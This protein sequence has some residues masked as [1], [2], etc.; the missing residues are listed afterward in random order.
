MLRIQTSDFGTDQMIGNHLAGYIV[1]VLTPDGVSLIEGVLDGIDW[2]E[3]RLD[4]CYEVRRAIDEDFEEFESEPE[5]F[6]VSTHTLLV[7]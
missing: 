7:A 5:L 2:D 3:G 6:E 4:L 1:D